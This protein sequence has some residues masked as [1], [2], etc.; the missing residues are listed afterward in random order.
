MYAAQSHHEA[1][2]GYGK[3]PVNIIHAKICPG[4]T[5]EC[6]HGKTMEKQSIHMQVQI[7]QV[8]WVHCD[9]LESGPVLSQPTGPAF[10]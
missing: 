7:C 6:A 4:Y 10:V 3:C 8:K 1:G 9:P 2:Q 5:R